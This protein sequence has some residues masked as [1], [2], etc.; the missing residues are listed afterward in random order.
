MG[1]QTWNEANFLFW[2]KHY[3]EKVEAF[4]S[5]EKYIRMQ[6]EHQEEL[7]YLER[8]IRGLKQE[9]AKSHA[10]NGRIVRCWMQVAEDVRAECEKEKALILFLRDP[11]VPPTNNLAKRCARKYKRKAH[12]VMSFRGDHGDEHFCNALSILETLKL[13]KLNLYHEVSSRFAPS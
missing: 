3:R 5:G 8:I 13:K 7:A 2:I 12:Q 9:L 10:E 11:T 4:E 6:K 1:S